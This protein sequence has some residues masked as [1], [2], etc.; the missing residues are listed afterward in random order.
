MASSPMFWHVPAWY[1]GSPSS[2]AGHPNVGRDIVIEL[3]ETETAGDSI[4]PDSYWVERIVGQ[5]QVTG[6]KAVGSIN[7]AYLHHR[8]YKCMSGDNY[9]FLRDLATEDDADTSWMMHKVEIFDDSLQGSNVG[10]WSGPGG[11]N[12]NGLVHQTLTPPISRAGGFDIKV[13]RKVNEGESLVW[14]TQ[15]QDITGGAPADDTYFLKMWVR[16]LL[17]K[18]S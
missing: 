12:A 3:L 14:Q 7:D 4:A 13:G 5:Y 17:R 16:V 8:V 9:L 6:F 10:S 1:S 18:V 15:I 2:I 11:A